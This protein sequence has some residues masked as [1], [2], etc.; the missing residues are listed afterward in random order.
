MPGSKGHKTESRGLITCIQ[1]LVEDNS[2]PRFLT[3]DYLC[4]SP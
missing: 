4:R 1:I 2:T 3:Q